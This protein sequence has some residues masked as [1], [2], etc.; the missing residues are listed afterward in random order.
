[1]TRTAV[2]GYMGAAFHDT[3]GDTFMTHRAVLSLQGRSSPPPCLCQT[4][5]LLP[6]RPDLP[7]PP[8]DLRHVL[9]MSVLVHTEAFVFHLQTNG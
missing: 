4:R 9:S 1:M 6:R 5:D 7:E 3:H 2:T 8:V